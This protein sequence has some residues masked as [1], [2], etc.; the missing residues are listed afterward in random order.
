M[1]ISAVVLKP[2]KFPGSVDMVCSQM[3]IR[4][5]APTR[6]SRVVCRSVGSFRTRTWWAF[7][8]S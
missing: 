4:P 6:V 3:K 1:R 8:A 5:Y 7:T 2:L